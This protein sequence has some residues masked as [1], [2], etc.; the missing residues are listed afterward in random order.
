MSIIQHQKNN[1][2]TYYRLFMT[3]NTSKMTISVEKHIFDIEKKICRTCIVLS[4]IDFCL[5]YRSIFSKT[6]QERS[7]RKMSKVNSSDYFKLTKTKFD[8]LEKYEKKKKS[9]IL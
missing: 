9:K 1:R 8:Y 3:D 7:N 5:L 6:C 2:L 4:D